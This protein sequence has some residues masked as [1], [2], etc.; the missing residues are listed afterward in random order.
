MTFRELMMTNDSSALFT[1]M[2]IPM[3]RVDALVD[4]VCWCRNLG[5]E[6]SK[7]SAFQCGFQVM[8][9]NSNGDAICHENSYGHE[10]GMWE[11]MGFPWDHG[12]VS[13]HTAKLAELLNDYMN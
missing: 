5:V 7:I 2:E 4:L 9:G 1:P 8:F 3:E 6:I 13:V 11:T 10:D 12:D